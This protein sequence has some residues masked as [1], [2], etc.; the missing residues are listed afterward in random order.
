MVRVCLAV[1]C[2][3][4][5]ACD[6]APPAATLNEIPEAFVG[7]WAP[8]GPCSTGGSSDV[9]ITHREIR[10]ADTRI[11]VTGVAPDGPAAARVDGRFTSHDAQWDGAV[12]LELADGGRE[13]N[14]VNGSPVQS[15]Q[16]CS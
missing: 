7:S 5:V 1:M 14:L 16:R 13:L 2:L 3:G 8:E 9:V 10:L 11:E 4:L 15:R 12:R 6:D